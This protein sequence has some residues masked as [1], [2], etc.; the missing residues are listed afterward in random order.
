LSLLLNIESCAFQSCFGCYERKAHTPEMV[1]TK[2]AIPISGKAM[3]I[4]LRTPEREVKGVLPVK[5]IA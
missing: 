5:L 2:S 4:S 3:R 1:E